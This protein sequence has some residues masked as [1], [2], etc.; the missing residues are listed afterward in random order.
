MYWC[1]LL[2]GHLRGVGKTESHS[3]KI[4]LSGKWC[5][6][7]E[8]Q[9]QCFNN[10]ADMGDPVGRCSL[11]G[12]ASPLPPQGVSLCNHLDNYHVSGCTKGAVEVV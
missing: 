6:I 8:Q 3:F 7:G 9:Y 12:V 5:D 2:Y 11:S 4:I 10:S 1:S